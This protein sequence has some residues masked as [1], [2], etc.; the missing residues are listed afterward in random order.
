M[1]ALDPWKLELGGTT[2]IEAS[3]GTGKTHTLTTLYVRMLVERDLL[4][5]EILV[6]TYTEAAMAELRERVRQRIQE[7]IAAG[8]EGAKEGKEG[9]EVDPRLRALALEARRSA[10]RR[11]GTDPLRRALREFDEAAIFTI[12]GFCQRT[13]KEH[14]FESGTAFDAEL[15]PSSES[16]DRT[17]AHDLWARIL[18][19]EALPFLEWLRSGAGRRW[20]FEP[21]PL[22]RT[23]LSILGAD[24]EMPV[25]PGSPPET[26]VPELDR[27]TKAVE[28]SWERWVRSWHARGEIVK[29]KLLGKNDLNKSKYKNPSVWLSW[30]ERWA[31]AISTAESLATVHALALPKWWEKL[32]PEGLESGTR[33]KGVVLEDEFF[34]RCGE[35]LETIAALEEMRGRRALALRRRFVDEARKEARKRREE[36]HLL[37]F[38]DLLCELRGALR[39]PEGDR[40]AEVLRGRYRFALIDEFQD[41]DP[42]QYEIFRRVWHEP[43]E[44]AAG[45]GGLI[46]IG[47]PKQ[48]IY[49][50][51]GA[52]VFTY[53]SARRDAGGRV[54]GLK[55]NWRSDAGLVRAVNALFGRVRQPFGLEGIGF[56]PVEA[57]AGAE[58]GWSVPGRSG[59]GL[60]VLMAEREVVG[61]HLGQTVGKSCPL[62]FGRT[63]LMDAFARDVADLLDSGAEID[64]RPIV[65]SDIAVL[66][67]RNSE[68]QRARRALEDMGIPCVDRGDADVFESR[69]AWEL[70]SL[71]RAFLRP[72]DPALLR[73][74]LATAAHGVDASGFAEWTDA[75]PALLALSERFAEYARIWSES[76]FGRAFEAWRR[77]EGVTERLL[78]F[79]DG[80]RRLTNW[81]HLAELLRQIESE[82]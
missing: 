68:L 41:T 39:P 10:E 40:L 7:V 2:L 77:A 9:S 29:G 79:E 38:D 56:D 42:V 74:A 52:D 14:A 5:R 62:R 17:L 63:D 37:Y 82:R 27:R 25:L 51:R 8:E 58:V 49:S 45:H 46:L 73:S 69:E 15:V 80:E 81:L 48:A 32:T 22:R 18:E 71:L 24:E 3:A 54:H 65:P 28:A 57:R 31:E 43:D 47:D 44:T 26:D 21:E 20:Q 60:R 76:G 19:G 13:L 72:G 53:L 78:R 36:R 23:L 66:G 59:A 6:V 33:K 64:G 4:P 1:N 70:A 30:I 50:F 67:R 12:H 61:A 11:G 55:T 75:S 16:L 34:E 35:V